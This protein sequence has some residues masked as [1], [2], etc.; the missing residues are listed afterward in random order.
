MALESDTARLVGCCLL[1]FPLLISLFPYAKQLEIYIRDIYIH[2]TPRNHW[3]PSVEALPRRKYAGFFIVMLLTSVPAW[4]TTYASEE[5]AEETWLNWL[6]LLAFLSMPT[7]VAIF[8]PPSKRAFDLGDIILIL[9]ILIPLEISRYT[10]FIPDEK[11][12]TS[13]KWPNIYTS[14][15]WLL[16][17]YVY[18][19]IQFY[20]LWKM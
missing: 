19:F 5:T 4:L 13:Y 16:A 10:P 9:F 8:R 3:G 6:I 7:F 15:I 14:Q 12:E 1:Y 20:D 2:K 17:Y 18:L 11:I